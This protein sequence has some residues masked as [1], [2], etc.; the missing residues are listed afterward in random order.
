MILLTRLNGERFALAIECIERGEERPDT[1]ITTAS[2]NNYVVRESLNEVIHLVRAE[3]TAVFGDLAS[4]SLRAAAGLR[5]LGEPDSE[6][7]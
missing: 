1:V 7:S 2:G 4:D 5:L 3:K 6:P